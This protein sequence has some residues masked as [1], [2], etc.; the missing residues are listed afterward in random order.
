MPSNPDLEKALQGLNAAQREAAETL[1]GPVVVIAGPGTGKTQ[2]VA[3]RAANILTK[4]DAKPENL[5]ITTFTEAGVVSIKKR[6]LKFLGTDAYRITVSTIHAFSNDVIRMFPEKFLR[7]RAMRPID[8]VEQIGLLEEIIENARYEYLSSDHDRFFYL[9]HVRDKIG[10]LKQEAVTPEGLEKAT[11]DLER[12]NAETLSAIKPE[13]KKYATEKARGEKQVGKLRD[14]ADAYRKYLAACYERG[15]YD[16]SDMITYVG[17]VLESDGDLRSTLAERFQFVM[18]D[19]FQDMSGAQN[20]VVDAIL[21]ESD[22][23]NVMA[24]GDDDQSIYR[25]QGASLENLFHFSKRYQGTKFV[26]L[27][28][29]YRST[30]AILRVAEKSVANN[31]ERIG[32]Y[33]P[34]I[35]KSLR[36]N[37]SDEGAVLRVTAFANPLEEK[38]VV[39][40]EVRRI[41]ERGTAPDEIAILTRTNRETQEWAAFL[42]ANG[43]GVESKAS[44]DALSSEAVTLALDLLEVASDPGVAEEKVIRLA[45][46]GIFDID[47]ADVLKINRALHK[48]NYVRKDRFKFLDALADV[49]LLADMGVKDVAKL[50]DFYAKIASAAPEN[51]QLYGDFKR[52]FESVG[53]LDFVEKKG[54]FS[55]LEDVFTLFET[56]KDWSERNPS[57]TVAG[58]LKKIGYYRKYSLDRK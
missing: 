30:D 34:N 16:F 12:E 8:D 43:I 27:T 25:F 50:A 18:L 28:D 38:A 47:P 11:D 53:F 36:S 57:L 44:A 21:S 5:L 13:L 51:V 48:M 54:S 46:S 58:F 23:P 26:V 39:L 24:V 20:R 40:R 32:N 52:I 33:V 6:L 29:N 10:K 14:L 2:I 56:A 3:C 49:E 42:A 4:T 7:F 17:E 55:D 22:V 19:E 15:F 37:R 35:V 41:L 31:K 1:Y 45:R 9:P